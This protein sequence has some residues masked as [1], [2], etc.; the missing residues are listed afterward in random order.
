MKKFNWRHALANCAGIL[1][2]TITQLPEKTE[3]LVSRNEK[4]TAELET[5]K[6][7]L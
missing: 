3:Q 7:K 2:T 5:L 4:L 1:N 6:E